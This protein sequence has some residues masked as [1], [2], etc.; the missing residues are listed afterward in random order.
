MRKI[1]FLDRDGVINKRLIADY[2]KTWDE[3]VFLPEVFEAVT[4]LNQKGYEIIIVSNQGGISKGLFK[5]EDLEKID[6]LMINEIEANKGKILKSYYCPHQDSDECVCRKPK[7]GLFIK[8]KQE[9]DIVLEKSWIIG[10]GER[11]IVAG[12]DSGC[13]SILINNNLLEK[14][15][16]DY[17]ADDLLSA[18]KI[19][20]EKDKLN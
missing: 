3:F 11:D 14:T 19:V 18:V 6:K 13:K 17:V 4:L 12:N 2:V 15:E 16:A 1:V 7:T 10:D 20:I 5:E 8:A 9:F